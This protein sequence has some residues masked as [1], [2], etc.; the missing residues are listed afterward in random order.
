MIRSTFIALTA[1]GAAALALAPAAQAKTHL[2]IGV[3][4]GIG[5]PYGGVYAG[6][7][8]YVDDGYGY[9]GDECHYITVKHKTL[10]ANGKLKVWYSKEL[11]CY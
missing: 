9:Y 3:G 2:N 5:V 10:K 6:G 7:P 1:A 8:I 11:V 4:L